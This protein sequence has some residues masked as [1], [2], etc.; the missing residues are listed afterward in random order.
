MATRLT[1]SRLRQIIRKE[2]RVMTEAP[3]LRSSGSEGSIAEPS[4]PGLKYQ[5]ASALSRAVDGL[6]SKL[7]RTKH[8]TG[9]SYGVTIMSGMTDPKY[10]QASLKMFNDFAANAGFNHPDDEYVKRHTWDLLGR[11]LKA[12][13]PDKYTPIPMKSNFTPW[14]QT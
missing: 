8:P 10:Q 13:K 7:A 3:R 9:G 14:S 4:V 11:D 12:G 1:E 6:M 2:I 5:S